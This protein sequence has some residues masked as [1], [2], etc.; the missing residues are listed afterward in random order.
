LDIEAEILLSSNT[1]DNS[2]KNG[3]DKEDKSGDGKKVEP[4]AEVA[5]NK[6]GK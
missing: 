1:N 4:K 6:R 2:G 5:V 3:N